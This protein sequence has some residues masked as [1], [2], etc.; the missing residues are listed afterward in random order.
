ML[1]KILI[2]VLLC[3]NGIQYIAFKVRSRQLNDARREIA[4]WKL[5]V[6]WDENERNSW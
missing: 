1:E 6:G 5:A 4:S 3:I 2:L